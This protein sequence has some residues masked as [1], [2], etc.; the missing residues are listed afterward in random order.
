MFANLF[1]NRK[2]AEIDLVT[3]RYIQS[4][5]IGFDGGINTYLYAGGNPVVR[6]DEWVVYWQDLKAEE[7]LVLWEEMV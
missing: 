6:V 5:R 3:G 1:A 2:T 4:D 7:F